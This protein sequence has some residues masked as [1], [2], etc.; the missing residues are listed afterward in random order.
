MTETFFSLKILVYSH[1]NR[2]RFDFVLSSREEVLQLKSLESSCNNFS[3]STGNEIKK[4]KKKKNS[5]SSTSEGVTI[6]YHFIPPRCSSERKVLKFLKLFVRNR[7]NFVIVLQNDSSD[8]SIKQF[9]LYFKATIT[10]DFI[11][12]PPLTSN[13]LRN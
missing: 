11:C 9:F 2:P 3:Q 10:Q 13:W 4:K 5:D 6:I 1:Q 7:N 12:L 8:D